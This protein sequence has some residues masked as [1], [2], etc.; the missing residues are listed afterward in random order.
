M[1]RLLLVSVLSIAAC[2]RGSAPVKIG[3]AGPWKEAYGLMNRR[4]IE[5]ALEE[6]NR[7]GGVNGHPLE[8]VMRDDGAD[9][10]TAAAIANEFLADRRI[11]AV[12]GHVNSGTMV[13]AA[14]VYDHGLPAVATSATSPDLTGISRWVFRVISSDSA[15][16][17]QLARFAGQLGRSRAAILYE[18]DAYGRGLVEAFRRSFRGD[19][20]SADPIEDTGDQDFE[21]YVA[22]FRR[23]RP[24]I[25]FVATTEAAGIALL[26]EAQRQRLASDFLGGDGWTG[27]VN[28]PKVAEGAYV[29]APFSAAD[30]RPEVQRFVASFRQKYGVTPDGNA[31]LAYDATR[32]LAVGISEVGASREALRAWLAA[33]GE[34][35]PGVSGPISFGVDGDPVG[36]SF[37]MT[38]VRGGELVVAAEVR[39]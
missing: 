32:L 22:T 26:R 6:I 36:K 23:S 39:P 28:D 1:N 31:A 30:P 38:R 24:D 8:V 33:L 34:P 4:G 27:V 21:P 25:V 13:A 17:V 5:L 11:T 20:V 15:N 29:G 10:A 3:A 2:S 37:V 19:V 16:G 18:N 14:R 7:D 9:G 12:V 35:Y